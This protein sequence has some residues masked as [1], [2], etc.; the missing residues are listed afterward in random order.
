MKTVMLNLSNIS[1]YDTFDQINATLVS[2][3][4]FY[5]LHTFER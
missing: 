3:R 1:K 4:D 5:R 2:M